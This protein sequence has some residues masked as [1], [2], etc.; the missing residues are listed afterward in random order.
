M[1]RY[2]PAASYDLGVH[3]VCASIA[4][5]EVVRIAGDVHIE[6]GTREFAE[7]RAADELA[8][9]L[10]EQIARSMEID[11]GDTEQVR[12]AVYPAARSMLDAFVD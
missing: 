3:I 4:P 10:D 6:Y 9:Y 7:R 1:I 2:N 12:R 5:D 8:A 11:L